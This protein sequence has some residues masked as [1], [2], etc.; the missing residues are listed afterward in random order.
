MSLEE[1]HLYPMRL[2]LSWC[3]QEK[4]CYH[5]NISL[6]SYIF[7]KDSIFCV[8]NTDI[9]NNGEEKLSKSNKFKTKNSL[10]TQQVLNFRHSCF[11]KYSLIR[12]SKSGS[13]RENVFV[14]LLPNSAL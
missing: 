10:L 11:L 14:L 12:G 9:E 13:Q 1:S 3:Y 8:S 4:T 2:A 5:T 6:G 7:S